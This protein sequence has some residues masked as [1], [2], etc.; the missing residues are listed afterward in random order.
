MLAL[1]VALAFAATP[2]APKAE[3]WTYDTFCWTAF[4]IQAAKVSAERRRLLQ[5]TRPGP[6]GII[7]F[8]GTSQAVPFNDMITHRTRALAEAAAQGVTRDIVNRQAERFRDGLKAKLAADPEA[9]AKVLTN[10]QRY[11]QRKTPG[12]LG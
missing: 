5:E 9:F 10:C 2:A 12:T 7:V 3:P 1:A 11:S 8:D 6:D 4:D